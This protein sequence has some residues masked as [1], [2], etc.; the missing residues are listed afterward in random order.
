MAMSLL[1]SLMMMLSI[2]G[3]GADLMD[4]LATDDYWRTKGVEV[5]A[6]MLIADATT[7]TAKT[8]P[9]VSGLIKQLGDDSFKVREAAEA[10]L[11][12]MGLAIA[13]QVRK[14]AGSTDAEVAVRATRILQQ[15]TGGTMGPRIRRLMAIRTLGE[16]KIKAAA[17]VLRT[18]TESKDF[19]VADYA[20]EAIAAIEGKPYQRKGAT[21]KQM[22]TDLWSLPPD[23]LIVKQSR[24]IRDRPKPLAGQLAMMENMPAAP[25]VAMMKRQVTKVLIDTLEM[26]GNIRLNASTIA[27]DGVGCQIV[28]R[29]RYDVEAVRGILR[30]FEGKSKTIDGVEVYDMG[31][32]IFLPLSAERFAM[33]AGTTKDGVLKRALTAMKNP[34]KGIKSNA[35]MVKLIQAAETNAPT[36]GVA[37]IAGP[38][39]K[40]E[41]FAAFQTLKLVGKHS[42]G[43]VNLRLTAV[44][45]DELK[46]TAAVEQFTKHLTKARET[47][48]R[49]VTRQPYLKSIQ[50]FMA[51]V[52]I[53]QTGTTAVATVSMNNDWSMISHQILPMIYMMSAFGPFDN[54]APAPIPGNRN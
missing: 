54:V 40:G 4:F 51:T 9:D 7:P 52:K 12:A 2:D 1:S 46:V 32:M 31:P 48:A 37:R 19:F 23:C 44:G 26:V 35:A 43:K 21:A 10:Q 50:Q 8:P 47:I 24:L 6:K 38:L 17:G 14:A 15:L 45:E 3:G 33:I 20:R 22:E 5:T 28:I 42:K 13:P 27:S 41:L 36:W 25:D 18:L 34:A 11:A 29:G 53:E 49:E 30:R 39:A 16:R